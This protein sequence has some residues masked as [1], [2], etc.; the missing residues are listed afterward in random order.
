M[1]FYFCRYAHQIAARHGN[2]H[3]FHLAGPSVFHARDY[4]ITS[5]QRI[6]LQQSKTFLRTVSCQEKHPISLIAQI[7]TSSEFQ[8]RVF[9]SCREFFYV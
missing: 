4:L 6:C 9:G 1:F 2:G 7:L 3:A 5:A 8:Y